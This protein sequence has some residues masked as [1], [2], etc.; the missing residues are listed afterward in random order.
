VGD[1]GSA[2]NLTSYCETSDSKVGVA[3]Y[4]FIGA[5]LAV[6]AGGATTIIPGGWPEQQL[7]L[8]NGS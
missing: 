8:V 4:T 6:P 2:T 5:I 7:F 1:S 3:G